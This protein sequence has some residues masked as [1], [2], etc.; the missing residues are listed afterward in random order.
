MTDFCHRI[1]VARDYGAPAIKGVRGALPLLA[2]ADTVTV[3]T[4]MPAKGDDL[5]G[6]ELGR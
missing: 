5:N 1:L 4:N 6:T 2:R 3:V